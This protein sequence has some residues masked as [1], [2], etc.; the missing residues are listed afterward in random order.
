MRTI[1]IGDKIHL[2]NTVATGDTSSGG[3]LH[4]R[5]GTTSIANLHFAWRLD[6]ELPFES[7]WS[8]GHALTNAAEPYLPG[9]IRPQGPTLSRPARTRLPSDNQHHP[10]SGG[11]SV[12]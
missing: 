3:I 7:Q 9:Q 11:H 4:V 10:P 2:L 8:W 6:V 12:S 1:T 5:N